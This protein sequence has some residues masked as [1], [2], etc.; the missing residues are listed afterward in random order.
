MVDVLAKLNCDVV[1]EELQHHRVQD[2]RRGLFGRR[3]DEAVGGDA[4]EGIVAF[5]HQ[6][7]HRR[8]ARDD[9]VDVADHLLGGG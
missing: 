5:G 9:L 7:E 4:V 8:I 6:R 2:R 3:H 1:G